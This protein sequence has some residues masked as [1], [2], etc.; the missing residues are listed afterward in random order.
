MRPISLT[1][2]AFGS[3]GARTTIRF[4]GLTQ[5]LFLITGD[6]GSGKSTL[7]DAIVFALYGEAS[8]MVNKKDGAQLQSQFAPLE[9]EPYVELVFRQGRDC[10]T[11]RRSPR[12]QRPLKR[13]KG[14]KDTAETVSL[15]MPDGTVY[16]P[17]ETDRKIEEIVGLTKHQFMQ[18]A[19][20]AQGEFMTLLRAKSDEK[21]VIFRKL[22][23]TERYPA[24][25]EELNRRRKEKEK[26]TAVLL[27]ACQT[28]TAHLILPAEDPQREALAAVLERLVGPEGN[29][30]DVEAL[31]EL[32]PGLIQRTKESAKEARQQC[33]MAA[34][35]RDMAFA[36]WTQAAQLTSLYEQKD[37]AEAE[38]T[39]LQAQE[40]EQKEKESLAERITRAYGLQDLWQRWEE[41]RNRQTEMAN[42][43][44]ALTAG[45]P[46]KQEALHRAEEASH[47]A[48]AAQEAALRVW[49]Q[50]EERVG[51]AK[52]IFA[53]IQEG[54][55]VLDQKEKAAQ[56]AQEASKALRESLD[57][58]IAKEEKAKQA[59]EGLG[60]AEAALVHW[61][62]EEEKLQALWQKGLEA[63]AAQQEAEKWHRQAQQDQQA[64]LTARHD[65]QQQAEKAAGLRM[66]F[67]DGQAGLLAQTLKDGQACPVCGSI[68]H[69]SPCPMPEG[70]VLD[71][72]KLEAEEQSAAV[73]R[74]TQE[75]A[76][77]QAQTSR[78]M[79]ED[80]QAQAR[81]HRTSL[82]EKLQSIGIDAQR[83]K[84][85]EV[86]FAMLQKS[87]EQTNA[88]KKE[89]Q[90]QAD[91]AHRAKDALAEYARR[92]E[93]RSARLAEQEGLVQQANLALQSEKAVLE[94][95]KNSLEFASLP[96]A[97]ALL[98]AAKAKKRQKEE[99]KNQAEQAQHQASASLEADR[100]L[101]NRYHQELPI[102]IE[103]TIARQNVYEKA[104][105][106]M[107]LDEQ[108]WR[109][110]TKTYARDLPEHLRREGEEHRTRQA[111]AQQSLAV[112]QE[113]IG[114]AKRPVME[115]LL[116]EKEETQENW[117]VR[118]KEEALRQEEAASAKRLQE[119]LEVKMA[120]R[121]ALVAE[122]ARL[123]RL[124]R[125]LSG[126]VTG[127]RMD[128]ET[129]VQRYYLSRILHGANLRFRE[130][131]SGQFELR[132]VEL[133]RAGEGKNRGL[134]L[135][136]YSA[137]T[138]KEREIGTL[139]GGESFLA[140]LALALGMADQIQQG[141]SA[142]DLGMMFIDEGFGSLD[143]QARAQAVRVL[144]EMAGGEKLV[145]II[146]HVTELKQQIECQLCVTKDEGG[147]HARWEMG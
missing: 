74:T 133:N 1:M 76:A 88:R 84:H 123:D 110:L 80:K 53:Q 63:K 67:L 121:S 40:E 25:V 81:Q 90:A 142:I 31:L 42:A 92:K 95:R 127:G 113:A 34:Q 109:V 140:A 9:T 129:Y 115:Q 120:A 111:A 48:K 16:P 144:Q 32:L 83:E 94:S 106:D 78:Q 33:E 21:K 27:T 73:L 136:V 49:S 14:T 61:Q 68:C 62:R 57:R 137:V 79:Q 35:R 131:S 5:N 7:F 29:I 139:S 104:V 3:Y 108:A 125:A 138:G 10:Y 15:L 54:Q 91:L 75:Q 43:Q 98:R 72:D 41:S 86:L 19:M 4:D 100:A 37:K 103:E 102:L 116:A 11:V 64:Y 112:A 2:E 119:V 12:H 141:A 114:Q 38:L 135:M 24:I 45:L 71:R 97:E 89:A 124:C 69:P 93:E 23:H 55:A 28:E 8:S 77:A 60:D 66:A 46:E 30:T 134:D 51:R 118:Q 146:S 44:A 26:E 101:L 20:I 47:Q 50:T 117:Q 17:K 65:Y 147:S 107:G 96:E 143:D 145:G 87:M 22:F 105:S 70:P 128:L 13:G 56:Q 58:L 130:M 99:Q 18:V 6:T 52:Q 36:Q 85:F 132:M 39:A 59:A 126:N 122:H 82:E